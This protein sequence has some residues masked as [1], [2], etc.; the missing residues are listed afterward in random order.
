MLLSQFTTLGQ[1][2]HLS[3]HYDDNSRNY[4]ESFESTHPPVIIIQ[5]RY[6][7]AREKHRCL[8]Q[9][10][11]FERKNEEGVFSKFRNQRVKS[12]HADAGT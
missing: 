2:S 9:L 11:T 3:E 4:E 6:V 5:D 7:K 8:V 10:W 12:C 1:I